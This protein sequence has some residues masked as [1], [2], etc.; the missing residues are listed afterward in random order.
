MYG[1]NTDR[2]SAPGVGRMRRV[3]SGVKWIIGTGG[4]RNRVLHSAHRIRRICCRGFIRGELAL[5]SSLL[6]GPALGGGIRPSG[7]EIA[8]NPR[9][10][11]AVD[12][13]PVPTCGHRVAARAM[14]IERILRHLGRTIGRACKRLAVLGRPSSS[15]RFVMA[16]KCSARLS[17]RRID[18]VVGPTWNTEKL[19]CALSTRD[20]NFSAS[21]R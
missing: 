21:S 7:A 11:F 2:R 8:G 10:V 14:G 1:L 13:E 16:G 17:S 18:S 15:C 9:L 3:H 4:R 5:V 12:V 20:R 19:T 6:Y